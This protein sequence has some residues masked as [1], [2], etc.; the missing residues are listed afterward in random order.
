MITSA[1]KVGG[2][3]GKRTK[4]CLRNIWM[5]PYGFWGSAWKLV[6]MILAVLPVLSAG[7]V[8]PVDPAGRSGLTYSYAPA[9][10]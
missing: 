1:Y 8:G 10:R 4:T 5:V 6:L 9:I 2:W 7:T 3:D